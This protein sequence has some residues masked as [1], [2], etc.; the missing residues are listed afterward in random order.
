VVPRGQGDGLIVGSSETTG[1]E[2]YDLQGER[3]GVVAA[4][5]VVGIDARFG[6][7]SADAW[8]VASLDGATNQLRLFELDAEAAS[9]TERTARPIPIGFSTESLCLYRDARD[10]TLYAFALGG[11]GEIAQY[12]ISGSEAGFDATLVRQLRV[13]SEVSY[14]TTDDA[15]G[16]LYVA[17]QGVGFWRFDADPEAEVVP[18][19][20]DAARL[21]RVTEEA[22]GL[23]VYNAGEAN[24]L[25]ASDASA[26]RFHIYDRNADHAFVGAFTLGAGDAVDGVEAA[27]GLSASSFGYGAQYPQGMLLAMDDENDGGTNYKLVSWADVARAQPLTTS[28]PQHPRLAPK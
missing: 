24:Y 9:A 21:G 18:Q 16:A 15:S 19:L 10:S 4:G 2:L 5:A 6:A 11:A 12:M 17:E 27:G 23:A 20:I 22:G 8:V 14:C 26:N 3:I 13:A 28:A 1:I 7:P 25:I